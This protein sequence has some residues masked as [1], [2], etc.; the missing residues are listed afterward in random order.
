MFQRLYDQSDTIVGTPSSGAASPIRVD[1]D[2]HPIVDTGSSF[3]DR[4]TLLEFQQMLRE[5]GFDGRVQSSLSYAS[6]SVKYQ[7]NYRTQTKKIFLHL[8]KV[9]APN[10]YQEIWRGIVEDENS[11][12]H[13]GDDR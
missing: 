13:S 1:D 2:Y 4:N 10:D 12:D 6:A 7:R 8:A 5:Q 9:M 11:H 3:Q